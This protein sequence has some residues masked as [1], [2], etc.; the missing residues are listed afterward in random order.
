MDDP[1]DSTK[2]RKTLR[3]VAPDDSVKTRW[4][5]KVT[6][7]APSV[8]GGQVVRFGGQAVGVNF[9]QLFEE[10]T[11]VE[12]V[13]RQK[14]KTP[15]REG[16]TDHIPRNLTL[17]PEIVSY[18]AQKKARQRLLMAWIVPKGSRRVDVA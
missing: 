10:K 9:E 8:G 3:H 7:V 15:M 16:S 18:P 13:Q 17:T 2:Q 11:L 14:P 12:L 5:A 1:G 6:V 4:V